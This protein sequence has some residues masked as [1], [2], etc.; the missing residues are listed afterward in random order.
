MKKSELKA[1]LEDLKDS[2]SSCDE[3]LEDLSNL[4]HKINCVLGIAFLLSAVSV[5]PAFLYFNCWLPATAFFYNLSIGL[6]FVGVA[7]LAISSS[8][9]VLN[10][11]IL[12]LFKVILKSGS[13][14]L[15][16]KCD[17]IK[18]K[19]KDKTISKGRKKTYN[20]SI[21]KVFDKSTN[22]DNKSNSK[23]QDYDDFYIRED[24]QICFYNKSDNKD[25]SNKS[26]VQRTNSSS[27]NNS[28]NK[29][30]SKTQYYEDFYI[31][32]GQIC[33]YNKSDNKD[34][35]NKSSVQRTNSSSSNNC[36]NKSN[37]KTQDYDDFYIREDG[38][39]CFYD[40]SYVKGKRRVRSR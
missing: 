22:S 34:N 28:D 8:I 27:A 11:L 6:A 5:V 16:N 40:N 15:A 26:S 33:F 13:N 37:S 3:E 35:S 30:N 18:K 20:K 1:K 36:D 32:N 12:G 9:L 14:S 39:I 25:N 7:G 23:T 31:E 2:K 17:N 21:K 10:N 29:S 38:Q 24:G 4:K 19:L